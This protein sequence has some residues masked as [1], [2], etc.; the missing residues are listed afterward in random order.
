V[1]PIEGFGARQRI[2]AGH[3]RVYNLG[4]D[5]FIEWY[6]REPHAGARVKGTSS[7][8][9]LRYAPIPARTTSGRDLRNV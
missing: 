2:V 6:F 8:L 9:A 5:E 7:M 4:L 1:A 3:K